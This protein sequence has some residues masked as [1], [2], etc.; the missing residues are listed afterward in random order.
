[1]AK[2]YRYVEDGVEKAGQL[3]VADPVVV[4]WKRETDATL[5]IIDANEDA[6]IYCPDLIYRYPTAG[7]DFSTDGYITAPADGLYHVS[8]SFRA[9]HNMAGFNGSS[10]TRVRVRL[11]CRQERGAS[12]ITDQL[13][14]EALWIDPYFYG[15][16]G[17]YGG[18]NII[19][20][21]GMDVELIAGDLLQPTLIVDGMNSGGEIEYSGVWCGHKVGD[22]ASA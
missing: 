1:M 2:N 19:L 4:R 3:D 6:G 5:P 16:I 14:G 12:L 7:T 9:Q 15:Y 11:C 13:I 17:G 22:L 8:F 18:A 21:G 20:S 10:G